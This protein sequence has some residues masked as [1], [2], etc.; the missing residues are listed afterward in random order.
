MGKGEGTWAESR[1][2]GDYPILPLTPS[3]TLLS[4][5]SL[6]AHLLKPG[7]LSFKCEIKI[8]LKEAICARQPIGN[9]AC[10]DGTYHTLP[11]VISTH[12]L[13]KSAQ[14]KSELTTLSV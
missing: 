5:S 4:V 13:R 11:R 6:Q 9:R 1:H 12:Q 14:N 7:F 2:R 8:I 10:T 3:P